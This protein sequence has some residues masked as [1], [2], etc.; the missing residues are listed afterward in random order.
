MHR[1]KFGD[2]LKIRLRHP[3]RP[4]DERVSTRCDGD[5]EQATDILGLPHVKEL[6]LDAQGEGCRL[7]LLALW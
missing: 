4:H 6:R 7:D 2:G 5:I 1:R 3:V